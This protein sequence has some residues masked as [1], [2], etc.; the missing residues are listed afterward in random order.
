MLPGCK[1]RLPAFKML[2][3]PHTPKKKKKKKKIN[4]MTQMHLAD[5]DFHLDLIDFV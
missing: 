2:L 3:S 4:K 1:K 5:T